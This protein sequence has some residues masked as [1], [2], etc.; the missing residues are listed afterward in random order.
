MGSQEMK[1][2]AFIEELYQS[3]RKKSKALYEDACRYLPG[4]DTR[5]ATYFKPFP[6]YISRGEGAYLY[7]VDDNKLLDFQNNYTS[8]IHGHAHQPT[9]EAVQEQIKHGS[10]YT[11]PIALQTQMAKILCE[12][13]PSIDLIRF[14]NSGTEANMHALRIARAFTGKAKLV[15][16]EGGYHGTT[17]VFEASVDPNIKKAGTLDQIKA[18]PESKGVS[19]NALKDVLVTPFN[20]IERTKKVI[21]KS[22]KEIACLIIEP[23]MGSAGQ[24]LPT[25]EYL[26]AIRELTSHY[27]IL[28]V[29]DEVVTG[30]LALGGAQE[31][32]G[33][34]PD[35]T[36]LGKI[37]GGGLPIGAFG[38]REDIMRLY[39]PREKKM[40]HSGTFNG[41]AISLAA[42]VATILAYDQTQVNYVNEL[43]TMFKQKLKHVTKKIGV[44]VEIN[45]IGSLYNTV[46]TNKAV[47]N[48]RDMAQSHE[49]LNQLLFM[50]LLTKGVF[51]ATRGMFCMSTA[52]KES[53]IDYA[54]AKIE[55]SLKEM[56]PVIGET[57][58]EL[59]N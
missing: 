51:I 31:V 13:F 52:M 14:T 5:T 38:G 20:D 57:A 16:I 41:N 3:K 2:K 1:Y 15:K 28:L 26:Q 23:V 54:I 36:A 9:V 43:G 47:V 29:F 58:P 27:G 25:M 24:I 39:D 56:M 7:D 11:A 55:E 32:F 44:H 34:I 8:L 35:L 40:Y 42:G 19:Q 50:T 18:I 45:G 33:V 10:A 21:E 49:G 46:F 12:R 48:Y 6:H 22:Y 4:G 37:I 53:D 17:D 30:R 59:I